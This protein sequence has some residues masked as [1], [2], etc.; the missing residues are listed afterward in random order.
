MERSPTSNSAYTVPLETYCLTS[1]S[2]AGPR[3]TSTDIAKTIIAKT[4]GHVTDFVEET[5]QEENPKASPPP[6]PLPKG[7]LRAEGQ[8][9]RGFG[10][11]AWG[12]MIFVRCGASQT[13]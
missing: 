13:S 1:T 8:K 12:Y 9:M 2:S 10:Y 3:C 5:V 11:Q 7:A 4:T 6:R